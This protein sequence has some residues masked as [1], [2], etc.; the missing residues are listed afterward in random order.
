MAHVNPSQSFSG[1]LH[2]DL[3]IAH[4]AKGERQ[5]AN[6][7]VCCTAI[8]DQQWKW[9]STKFPLDQIEWQFTYCKPNRWLRTISRGGLDFLKIKSCIS[10]IRNLQRSRSSLLFTHEAE[11]AFWCGLLIKLLGIRASHVAYSFN[12]PN[13]PQ[14]IRRALMRY[15]L[16]SVDKFVVYSRM[17]RDLYHQYFGIP[18]E[19]IE[20]SHWKMGVPDYAPEYPL[21][22]G[23]YICAMGRY[24]RDYATL[25]AAMKQLPHINLVLV[26]GNQNLDGLEVPKNVKVLCD[27]SLAHAYNILQF[28]QFMVLPLKHS[29]MP[30]GHI[31]LVS[32]MHLHKAIVATNSTGID[33]YVLNEQTGLLTQPQD[34]NGLVEAISALD[35]Q[36]AWREQLAAYGHAFAQQHCSEESAMQELIQVLV[37]HDFLANA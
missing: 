14:G 35:R 16:T 22:T 5:R 37:Q 21:E 19:K 36:P 1:P 25:L 33:D 3:P 2:G 4:P 18:A 29:E 7:I 34:V 9:F 27:I 17:E 6:A 15:A 31:T 23:N 28:S 10:A 30:T 11:L 20:F 8:S 13:R 32:A 26:T 24:G 12:Y